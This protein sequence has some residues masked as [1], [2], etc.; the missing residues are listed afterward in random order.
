MRNSLF[1][2]HLKFQWNILLR[3]DQT[4]EDKFGCFY[5]VSVYK[6]Y[7]KKEKYVG[8]SVQDTFKISKFW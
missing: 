6:N 2:K 7:F 8:E 5:T 4:Q 1:K 3:R